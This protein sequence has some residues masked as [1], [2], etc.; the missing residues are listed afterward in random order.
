MA[1]ALAVSASRRSFAP[2][3]QLRMLAPPALAFALSL[4]F[5][6]LMYGVTHIAGHLA[7]KGEVLPTIDFVRLKRDTEIETLER[8]KPPPPPPQEPPPPARMK[9]AASEAQQQQAP[10]PF[11]MPN[12]DLTT[13]VGG[14]PFI[15]EMGQGGGT[16]LAGLFDGDI[17]PLQRLPPQYPRDAAR[18]RIQ[19]WVQLEVQVNADGSV[20]GARVMDAKPKGLFEASAVAAVLKWKFK[21]R[22]VNGQPVAQRGMQK[23]EFNLTEP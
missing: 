1:S 21:P 17:I 19:G 7:N 4:G 9:V 3:P 12:L 16:A 11:A 10:T 13:S 18:N 20:R 8:R 22:V 23:I 5:F 2:L 14:G 6:W 15:G